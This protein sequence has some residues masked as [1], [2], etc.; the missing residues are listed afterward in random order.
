[1]GFAV[2]WALRAEDDLDRLPI[3]LLRPV[4]DE[5]YRLAEDP[6][7]LSSP[8]RLGMGLFQRYYFD[9]DY[10]GQSHRFTILFQYTQDEMAIEIIGVVAAT[11]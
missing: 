3:D 11:L 2:D 1:M 10:Q 4:I 8:P 5:I 7:H 9:L 6:V